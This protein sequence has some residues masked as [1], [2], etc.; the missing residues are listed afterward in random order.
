MVGLLAAFKSEVSGVLADFKT[1]KLTRHGELPFY[2]GVFVSGEDVVLGITGCGCE[3]AALSASYLFQN[4]QPEILVSLG[5]CGAL[6]GSLDTGNVVVPEAVQFLTMEGKDI[7]P[8]ESIDVDNAL[9]QS[10]ILARKH[11]GLLGAEGLLLT[12]DRLVKT[13]A[14]KKALMEIRN[15]TAVDMESIALA[16]KAGEQGVP[17]AAARVVLDRAWDDLVVD[18]ESILKD[19]LE[20]S[21]VDVAGYLMTHPNHLGS[22]YRDL[23]RFF[24]ASRAIRLLVRTFM[25]QRNL[26]A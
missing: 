17:F 9:H 16:E 8:R 4:Y 14:E 12:S 23:R 13:V 7:L 22:F 3:R 6:T 5:T 20:P 21:A 18:Y 26:Y 19:R 15:A 11:S 1:K 2:R 10:L 25:E 24:R